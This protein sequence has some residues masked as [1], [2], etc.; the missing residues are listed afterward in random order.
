MV[1]WTLVL[2]AV[3]SGGPALPT[4]SAWQHVGS[5][6]SSEACERVR[7]D[8]TARAGQGFG[9]PWMVPD[10]SDDTRGRPRV[11]WSDSRCVST[12]D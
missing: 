5:F 6:E 7:A 4:A 10:R 2:P 3:E 12:D 11:S 9:D 8:L 1:G